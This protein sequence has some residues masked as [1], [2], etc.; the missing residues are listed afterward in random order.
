[1]DQRTISLYLSRI[2][3][4]YYIFLHKNIRYKLIYPNIDIKYQA[5][6]YAEE[7]YCNNRF[8]DWITEDMAVDYLVSMGL[9]SP[10]GD[11]NLKN[12]E[13]QVD[14]IKIDLYKN[15]LNPTKIKQL[16][17]NLLNIKNTYNRLYSTRHY[18][19][20]YTIEGYTQFLKNQY[21]L[22]YSLFDIENN[23][24][25]ESLNKADPS[26]LNSLS[27]T[28]ITNTIDISTF[29]YIARSDIWRNFWSANQQ[30]LFDKSTINWTD[31][32]KTLVVLTKMYDSA[33]EHPDCPPDNIFEDD[34]MFDGWMLIQKKENE[35]TRNKNRTEKM[36][37]GKKLNK[38]GEVFIM[39][40]S[41]EEAQNIYSLN[42]PNSMH[43]I[44]ERNTIIRNSQSQ[45]E[46][47]NLPDV[48]RNLVSQTNEQFKNSRRK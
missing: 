24:I 40:N 5:E 9:W 34:D 2:L 30:N 18:L 6:I 29:R 32:Q 3:S 25:F 22:V 19:D 15:F 35:K 13:Q 8:N 46:E 31:E 37:E 12:L 10:N 4:G 20:Q 11:S 45:I 41:Q 47:S 42:D 21:I 17:R 44:R 36:L 38:A 1:M 43:I 16:R 7:E 26:L 33:H 14:D 28:L 39:A 48:Q 27:D 23:L